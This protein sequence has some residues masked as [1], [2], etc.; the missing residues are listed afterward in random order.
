SRTGDEA[1]IGWRDSSPAAGK[2]RRAG[3]EARPS[4]VAVEASA[5]AVRVRRALCRGLDRALGDLLRHC[6]RCRDL[7]LRHG[8]VDRAEANAAVRR[9]EDD[10]AAA[11]EP[12]LDQP[13]DR[14]VDAD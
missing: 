1:S 2:A 11:E 7:G 14:R 9:V 6:E 3:F 10:V 4:L 5:L 13:R 12:A 8:L